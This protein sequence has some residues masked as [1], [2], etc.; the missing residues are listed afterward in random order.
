MFPLDPMVLQEIRTTSP[1]CKPRFH[2]FIGWISPLYESGYSFSFIEPVVLP[3]YGPILVTYPRRCSDTFFHPWYR[4]RYV[5]NTKT[6]IKKISLDLMKFV[7]STTLR[8]VLFL[9]QKLTSLHWVFIKYLRGNSG[10][11]VF[12]RQICLSTRTNFFFIEKSPKVPTDLT[13]RKS[14][15]RN[16]DKWG[17]LEK[18]TTIYNP[19]M[20]FDL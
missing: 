9:P 6:N 16:Y 11:T 5:R 19:S 1:I 18:C 17:R 10:K 2:T 20:F 3:S 14:L 8:I 4:C 15:R 7:K 13:C 12:L